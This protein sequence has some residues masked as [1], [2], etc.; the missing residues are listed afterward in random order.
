MTAKSPARAHH[1]LLQLPN[2]FKKLSHSA[3]QNPSTALHYL[4]ENVP[5]FLSLPLSDSKMESTLQSGWSSE[6]PN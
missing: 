2:T 5:Q 1:S 3:N 6:A 4:Q